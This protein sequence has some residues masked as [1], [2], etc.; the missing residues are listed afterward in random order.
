M[1]DGRIV[2]FGELDPPGRGLATP[3][4]R[5][6]V[7][8][9]GLR[10]PLLPPSFGLRRFHLSLLSRGVEIPSNFPTPGC[11]TLL[12]SSSVDNSSPHENMVL[13]RPR[14]IVAA[15]GGWRCFTILKQSAQLAQWAASLPL[16]ALAKPMPPNRNGIDANSNG[17]TD[18]TMHC[19]TLAS[20]CLANERVK[21]CLTVRNPKLACV[22]PHI[23]KSSHPDWRSSTAGIRVKRVLCSEDCLPR[24]PPRT[25]VAL[26]VFQAL[27]HPC[28][29]M[30]T[31]HPLSKR[32]SG[33]TRLAAAV[34][35]ATP[36]GTV[37]PRFQ[38]CVF[39]KCRRMWA[40]RSSS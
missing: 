33:L 15:M 12:P 40:W 8:S 32:Q 14:I 24:S 22:A 1:R 20:W 26:W 28:F 19:Q 6:N 4:F 11:R 23:N 31:V 13:S 38:I 7:S 10:G 36:V 27:A 2:T 34:N 5:K 16:T 25:Q 21:S 37:P 30:A 18:C 29:P 3:G 35:S 9:T 17:S 39:P